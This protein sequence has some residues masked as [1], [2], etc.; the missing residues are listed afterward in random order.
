MKFFLN[1]IRQVGH[2]CE[3]NQPE[4]AKTPRSHRRHL[5]ADQRRTL[6]SQQKNR[7]GKLQ[8]AL[9]KPLSAQ[10]FDVRRRKLFGCAS[11]WVETIELGPLDRAM[12]F[13]RAPR[14]QCG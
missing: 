9:N 2:S 11:Q 7:G 12:R 4:S 13:E 1:I 8:V 5:A 3:R 14:R 10:G 6:F